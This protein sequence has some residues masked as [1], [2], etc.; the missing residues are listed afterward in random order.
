MGHKYEISVVIPSHHE[1]RLAHHTMKS[2]FRAIEHAERHGI[3]TE[4]VIVLD[5]ADEQTE[6]Y[7]QK[8]Q[9]ENIRQYKVS[10]GDLGLSRNY[11][12]KVSN[13]KYIAFIDSD[14]L[15]G[16]AWLTKVYLEA[17]KSSEMS[18][19]H[20]QYSIYFGRE[21]LLAKHISSTDDDFIVENLF[22]YN[23]WIA[24]CFASKELLLANPYRATTK[25]S[26][27]GYEDWH[28][29]CEVIAKGINI[30]IVPE[31]CIFVRRKN[32]GSLLSQH[33]QKQAMIASTQLF[34]SEILS[35]YQRVNQD[36]MVK[37]IEKTEE[38]LVI[39]KGN[40]LKR[41]KDLI[42]TIIKKIFKM[43]FRFIKFILK[44]F[45]NKHPRVKRLL[46]KIKQAFEEFFRYQAPI[47]NTEQKQTKRELYPLWLIA[48]CNSIHQLEPQILYDL[49]DSLITE[50]QVPNSRF[51][52]EYLELDEIYGHEISHVFLVPFI[53]KGGADLVILNYINALTEAKLASGIVVIQ[54][55]N[56][57]SVWKD[58]LPSNVKLIEFGSKYSFLSDDE[59]E[60]L[61]TRLLLQKQPK[62][63][64]NI[65]SD[66]GY[67][68]FAKYGNALSVNSN[69]F[70][71]VFLGDET[72]KGKL[73]G[74]PYNYL[75]KCYDYLTKVFCDNQSFLD[76]LREIYGFEE[77]K[78]VVHYTPFQNNIKRVRPGLSQERTGLNILWAGRLDYQKRPDIL[79]KVAEKCE[80]YPFFFHVYGESTL[81]EDI[82]TSK[83]R[84]LKN[85]KMYGAFDG[86]PS[87][88]LEKFDVLLFTSQF[89]GI[90]TVLIGAVLG[91]LP[92]VASDVG[93]IKE[94]IQPD[95]T[96]FLI[97]PF[98]YIDKYVECLLKINEDR[99]SLA[100]LSENAFQLAIK[101]HSWNNFINNLNS[102]PEYIVH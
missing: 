81:D 21:N 53:I 20:P 101:R 24:L 95:E 85:V 47:L 17:E 11:G 43:V 50:Y 25:D 19:F 56:R 91:G 55:I 57:E 74:Y 22:E 67:R 1:G 26:P 41:I 75:P 16:E 23:Y 68:I 14:D 98:D 44:P 28:F 46:S 51:G 102:L 99:S 10:F 29:Y 18:I 69:L 93:G 39:S 42:T 64:H 65:Q 38:K 86:F 3:K 30:K 92:V 100:R 73:Q 13:A 97:S 58:R 70:V 40:L 94:L 77:E 7:F 5:N 15:F 79:I 61:L 27:F 78:L 88:P 49:N 12:V 2:V 33:N 37:G 6:L 8:Y 52:K 36:Q 35:K 32:E 71:S 62:V 82:Y 84:K 60:K 72:N 4:I 31:T 48:E 80:A 63:I 83:L 45:I 54:T 96:G 34:R 90:P 89:E 59:Q 87:L 76:K 66:L 9:F